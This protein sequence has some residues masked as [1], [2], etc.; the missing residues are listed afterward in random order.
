MLQEFKQLSHVQELTGYIVL[1][2]MH[3]SCEPRKKNKTPHWSQSTQKTIFP[4]KPSGLLDRQIVH[5]TPSFSSLSLSSRKQTGSYLWGRR[6]TE[7]GSGL[8][9]TPSISDGPEVPTATTTSL[10]AANVS[11]LSELL[12]SLTL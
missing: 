12:S 11:S 7:L 2:Q 6:Q 8:F 5:E 3:N 4:G 9:W 10:T 1:P